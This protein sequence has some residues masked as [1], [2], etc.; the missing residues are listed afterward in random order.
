MNDVN[1]L[2]SLN[3]LNNPKWEFLFVAVGDAHYPVL[4]TG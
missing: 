3:A 2:R 4:H 1:L